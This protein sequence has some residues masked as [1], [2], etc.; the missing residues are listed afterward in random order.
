MLENSSRQ[1]SSL[2]LSQNP[3]SSIIREESSKISNTSKKYNNSQSISNKKEDS[4]LM[5]I[6]NQEEDESLS[7]I[8]V[9][10]INKTELS[11]GKSEAPFN[12]FFYEAIQ[13][14]K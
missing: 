1:K 7:Q 4:F 12:K 3:H 9:N 6:N 2:V 11:K 8:F 13:T 10:E 14:L 5:S